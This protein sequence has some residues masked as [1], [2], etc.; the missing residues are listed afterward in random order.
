MIARKNQTVNK[1]MQA[2][3]NQRKECIDLNEDVL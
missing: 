3:E 1:K 2:V